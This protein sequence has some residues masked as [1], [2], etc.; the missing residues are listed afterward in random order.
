MYDHVNFKF[1][2]K[3]EFVDKAVRCGNPDKTMFW[4][5]AGVDFVIGRREGFA[6]AMP[7]DREPMPQADKA[8]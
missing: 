1:G 5:V 7:W 2:S 6:A 4:Q 8:A 3:P